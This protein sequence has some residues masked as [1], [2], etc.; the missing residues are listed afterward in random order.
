MV[1]DQVR[2]PSLAIRD[3][4]GEVWTIPC[5]QIWPGDLMPGVAV[6]AES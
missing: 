3:K 4:Q 1:L 6:V 5:I 2:M